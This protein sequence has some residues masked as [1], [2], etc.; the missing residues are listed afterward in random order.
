M[1]PLPRARGRRRRPMDR[2]AEA[3]TSGRRL[4]FHQVRERSVRRRGGK[5]R[6]HVAELCAREAGCCRPSLAADCRT[7][8]VE[9]DARRRS[10]HEGQRLR[11]GLGVQDGDWHGDA[12]G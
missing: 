10:E 12:A 7:R 2:S 4:Q 5:I 8:S 11:A 1:V 9:P 6:A 3:S